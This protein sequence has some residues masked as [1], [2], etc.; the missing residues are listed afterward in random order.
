MLTGG[1]SDPE[2]DSV[3]RGGN[4]PDDPVSLTASPL[5][6]FESAGQAESP[7]TCSCA[8]DAWH[9]GAAFES[10]TVPAG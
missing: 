6:T 8:S 7:W 9:C 10:N 1:L 2:L 3:Y 4:G 5:P